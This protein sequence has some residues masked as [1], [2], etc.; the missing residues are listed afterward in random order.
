MPLFEQKIEDY[1]TPEE[2]I[3]QLKI[4]FK[5]YLREQ[6]IYVDTFTIERDKKNLYCLFFFA[7]H[8]KGFEAMLDTKWKMDEQQGKGF[9]I[10][11]QQLLF[12]EVEISNYPE[13]LKQYILQADYRTNKDIYFF[14]LDNGFLPRHTNE[15]FKEWQKSDKKFKIFLEDGKEARKNSFYISYKN[16]RNNPEKRVKFVLK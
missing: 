16:S 8:I 2:F 15:V 9:R 4:S 5:Q 1:K 12:S 3:D 11:A 6:R 7:P 14:G 13:K 10:S